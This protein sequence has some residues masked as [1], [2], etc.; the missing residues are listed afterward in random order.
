MNSQENQS[1]TF[2]ITIQFF[3]NNKRLNNKN[4]K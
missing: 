2:K 4:K 3:F 1:S